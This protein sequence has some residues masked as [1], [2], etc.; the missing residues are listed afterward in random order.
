MP[1]STTPVH[2][3]KFCGRPRPDRI[4]EPTSTRRLKLKTS[5]STIDTE[6]RHELFG[7]AAASGAATPATNTI[8]RTG[9][10]HGEIPAISPAAKATKMSVTSEL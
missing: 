5:P 10:M 3:K 9:K 6:R 2:I 1:K 7:V 4:S 8:G